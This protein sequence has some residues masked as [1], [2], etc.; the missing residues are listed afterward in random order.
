MAHASALVASGGVLV[1]LVSANAAS[2]RMVAV[3]GAELCR[4]HVQ[5][6][7]L[8]QLLSVQQHAPRLFEW[9]ALGCIAVGTA[10][11]PCGVLLWLWERMGYCCVMPVSVYVYV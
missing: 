2:C 4:R 3:L 6:C 11:L 7:M 1:S 5:A 9:E 8:S 10:F